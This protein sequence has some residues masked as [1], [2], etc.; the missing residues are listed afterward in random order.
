MSVLD[1]EDVIMSETGW[2]TK[3]LKSKPKSQKIKITTTEQARER[4]IV[5][6]S[7]KNRV[8][9]HGTKSITHLHFIISHNKEQRKNCMKN[10]HLTFLSLFKDSEMDLT[11][12]S[13]KDETVYIT[14]PNDLPK[15]M[16]EWKQ[17]AHCRK[18]RDFKTEFIIKASMK[19][20]PS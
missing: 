9:F 1:D 8:T 10:M 5:N 7:S 16:E 18:N 12:L 17:I 4:T 15:E 19:L 3:L 11:I 20:A 2:K 14:N 13:L 6:L